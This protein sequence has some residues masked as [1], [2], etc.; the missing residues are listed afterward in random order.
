[1]SPLAG[2][3]EDGRQPAVRDEALACVACRWRQKK[4][5]NPQST[6]VPAAQPHA[7]GPSLTARW[8]M[9]AEPSL[10]AKPA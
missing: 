5:E 1:L 10:I 4:Y 3:L 2:H 9:I 6:P 7:S 8:A